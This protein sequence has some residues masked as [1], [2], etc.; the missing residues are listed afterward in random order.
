MWLLPNLASIRYGPSHL[1]ANFPALGSLVFQKKKIKYQVTYF[2]PSDFDVLV[3][4]FGYPFLIIRNA[5]PGKISEFIDNVKI[6]GQGLIIV[7]LILQLVSF[8]CDQYFIR[9]H[10]FYS[11]H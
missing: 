4:C 3:I 6:L 9:D 2:K 7:F 10:N 11:K 5:D 8:R 1:V